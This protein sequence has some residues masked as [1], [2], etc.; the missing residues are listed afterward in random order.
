MLNFCSLN[1]IEQ[2]K[3]DTAELTKSMDSGN[4]TEE[5]NVSGTLSQ[6]V[7]QPQQLEN[8]IKGN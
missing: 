4:I 6:S 3:S 5:L 1:G 8:D 2:Q 7:L